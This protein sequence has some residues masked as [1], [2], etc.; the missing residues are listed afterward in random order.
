[1]TMNVNYCLIHMAQMMALNMT[2]TQDDC[3]L[4]N[5]CIKK[6]ICPYLNT[7]FN[8]CDRMT[9]MLE[10]TFCDEQC[11]RAALKISIQRAE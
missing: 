6:Y 11:R 10:M 3:H 5:V 2:S 7:K 4:S 9:Y 8:V 1:M